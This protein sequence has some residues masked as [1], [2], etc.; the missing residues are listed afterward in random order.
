MSGTK[1][2]KSKEV[3][4]SEHSDN[5]DSNKNE[6]IASKTSNLG[7]QPKGSQAPEE[8]EIVDPVGN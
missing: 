5:E 3:T 6:K 2:S 7:D 4:L 1:K 8:G